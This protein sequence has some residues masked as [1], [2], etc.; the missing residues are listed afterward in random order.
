MS[1]TLAAL[2]LF[3]APAH[4]GIIVTEGDD[5]GMEGGGFEDPDPQPEPL[6][7]EEPDPEPWHPDDEEASAAEA[8]IC[9]RVSPDLEVCVLWTTS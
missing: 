9:V 7:E 3:A 5:P 2:L 8:S 4:A 1:T 6:P